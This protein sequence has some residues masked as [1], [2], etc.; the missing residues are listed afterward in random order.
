[1]KVYVSTLDGGKKLVK[2]AMLATAGMTMLTDPDK[3]TEA[4]AKELSKTTF[5]SL[6]LGR[7]SPI[8]MYKV[9]ID[10]VAPERVHTHLIRHHKIEPF[11]ATS[12]PDI[13][14]MVPLENGERCFSLVIDAKRLIEISWLRRCSR[15]WIDTREVFDKIEE[16]LVA[17]EPAFEPFLKPSCIWMGMCPEP[18]L[19][20]KCFYFKT[21]RAKHERRNLLK[22]SRGVID[23][24]L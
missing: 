15:A 1:M 17:M 4:L 12:R 9:W 7:H 5:Q 13:S 8:N 11:V 19:D 21:P 16:L 24:N 3:L 6:L 23:D 14:Y 2:R 10:I 22:L 18:K 20:N